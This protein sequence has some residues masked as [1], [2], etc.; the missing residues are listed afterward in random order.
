MCIKLLRNEYCSNT[1]P[2]NYDLHKENFVFYVVRNDYYKYM[3][4]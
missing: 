4:K 2:Y 3:M 1:Q